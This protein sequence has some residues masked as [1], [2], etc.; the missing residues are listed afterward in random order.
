MPDW[1]IKICKRIINHRHVS[2]ETEAELKREIL[3]FF[4]AA[5]SFFV[6]C[7]YDNEKK[8]KESTPEDYVDYDIK[9]YCFDSGL[10]SLIHKGT[11]NKKN[12]SLLENTVYL[13]LLS[14]GIEPKGTYILKENGEY[15]EIDFYFRKDGIET[16]I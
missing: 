14:R 2:E 15:G 7:D 11:I 8:C 12:S 10:L 1:R 13:E 9:K 16:Y 3:D 4:G 6:L 5:S